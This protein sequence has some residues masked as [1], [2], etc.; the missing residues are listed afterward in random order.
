MDITEIRPC[1]NCGGPIRP[2]FV[3]LDESQAIMHGR[4][5]QSFIG[6]SMQLDMN[7]KLA[8]MFSP[9]TQ[10]AVVAGDEK[11]ALKTRAILCQPCYLGID[12][13][14]PDIYLPALFEKARDNAEKIRKMREPKPESADADSG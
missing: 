1:D 6:L 10:A 4:N 3:V 9:D 12:P 11:P 2:V 8:Q 14:K 7:F 13:D 5:I